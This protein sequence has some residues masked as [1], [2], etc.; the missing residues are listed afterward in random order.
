MH[1]CIFNEAV[2]LTHSQAARRNER[3]RKGAR[4][5]TA[6][7]Y[8]HDQLPFIKVGE[9]E[10]CKSQPK[11]EMFRKAAVAKL[12][13]TFALLPSVHELNDGIGLRV[14]WSGSLVLALSRN[15][16]FQEM[17]ISPHA[18]HLANFRVAAPFR[19]CQLMRAIL[20]VFDANCIL[21]NFSISFSILRL[22]DNRGRYEC[23][24]TILTKVINAWHSNYNKGQ[25]SFFGL[26]CLICSLHRLYPF[27]L[28]FY[29][30]V[31]V[32][33][34]IKVAH[35]HIIRRWS[36][37]TTRSSWKFKWCWPSSHTKHV[38]LSMR[39]VYACCGCVAALNHLRFEF[40][41]RMCV[42]VCMMLTSG[43][44]NDT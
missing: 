4:E 26:A 44:F 16:Q 10:H 3:A 9:T 28:Q 27:A 32:F 22:H 19:Q 30:C 33:V 35:T 23:I 38:H 41:C 6:Q 1:R 7:E 14:P 37:I 25:G 43:T 21:C 24:F 12:L 2:L 29:F 15:G 18:C 17:W 8:T 20:I 40:L 5:S 31:L 42:C 39:K 11:R 13:M 36:K 34:A